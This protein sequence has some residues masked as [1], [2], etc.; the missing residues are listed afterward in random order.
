[1]AN[2][3]FQ[4]IGKSGSG[5]D[6]IKNLLI[7]D[8]TEEKWLQFSI[9]EV[10]MYTTRPKREGEIDGI[11]YFFKTEEEY[12]QMDAANEILECRSYET[13]HGLWRYFTPYQAFDLTNHNYLILNTLEGYQSLRSY[14]GEDIVYPFYIEVEDGIRLDR[15]LKRE[16]Q[17]ENPKYQ[18]L[19]RRF[20]ADSV[21]FSDEKLSILNITKRYQ[22]D[23][24]IKCKDEIENDIKRLLLK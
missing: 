15:A 16:M 5:K 6:T 23:N 13:K 7:K 10:V 8:F 1:M 4:L 14:Y 21:D 22:N 2:K 11:S 20:L 12:Q 19:C 17:E 24:L 9:R 3:I 18:E